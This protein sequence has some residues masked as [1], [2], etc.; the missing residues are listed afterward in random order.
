MERL[1]DARCAVSGELSAAVHAPRDPT[2]LHFLFRGRPHPMGPHPLTPWDPTLTPHGTP[3]SHPMGPHP[4]TPWD[5]ALSPHGTP[6]SSSSPMAH[7]QCS[8]SP[9]HS[10][11]LLTA[12]AHTV[13]ALA[14][15]LVA[16][17]HWRV[18]TLRGAGAR[19]STASLH[20][21]LVA[22]ARDLSAALHKG[23][24][25]PRQYHRWALVAAG[26]RITTTTDRRNRR[27]GRRADGCVLDAEART[28]TTDRCGERGERGRGEYPAGPRLQHLR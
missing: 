12:T 25:R 15:G 10:F 20:P 27:T 23:L 18:C 26:R 11:P 17:S 5:P 3:P 28:A 22:T 7:T 1:D 9:Q 13:P 2:L 14:T 4:L 6:P 21:P 8:H 24:R 16:S 19:H